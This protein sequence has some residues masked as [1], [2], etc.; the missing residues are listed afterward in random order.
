MKTLLSVLH[1]PCRNRAGRNHGEGKT[2]AKRAHHRQAQGDV[3]ELEAPSKTVNAAGQGIRPPVIP[4]STICGVV[5]V[6]PAKRLE[7]S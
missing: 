1:T 5:T 2:K 6:R 7:M 3:L 4:K